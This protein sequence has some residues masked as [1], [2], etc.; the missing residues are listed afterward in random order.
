[1][2][3]EQPIQEMLC[4]NL[5]SLQHW[6]L[7]MKLFVIIFYLVSVSYTLFLL[8]FG[9]IYNYYHNCYIYIYSFTLKKI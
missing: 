6:N 1:M 5:K 2:L 4:S 3:N 7:D 9:F 8:D